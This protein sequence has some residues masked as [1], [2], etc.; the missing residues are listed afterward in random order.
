MPN[1]NSSEI[2][3]HEPL[4]KIPKGSESCVITDNQLYSSAITLFAMI[5]VVAQNPIMGRSR[6][7]TFDAELHVI[8]LES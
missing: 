3:P 7:I 2:P 5:R 8:I 4:P 6:V 1:R